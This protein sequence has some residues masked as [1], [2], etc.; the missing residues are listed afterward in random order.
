MD[1]I[2]T[3]IYR[4]SANKGSTIYMCFQ[5]CKESEKG[6]A[7]SFDYN[8]NI[9]TKAIF[10]NMKDEKEFEEFIETKMLTLDDYKRV[11]FN[12]FVLAFIS[13]SMK[14]APVKC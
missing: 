13:A 5:Y 11:S 1:K 7:I 10:H 2:S 14:V 9:K 12:D 4:G 3:L 8:M 6:I